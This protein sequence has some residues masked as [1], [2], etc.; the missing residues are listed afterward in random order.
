MSEIRHRALT[1]L[2]EKANSGFSGNK[3]LENKKISEIFGT[4]V[5][6]MNTMKEYLTEG[7]YYAILAVK[8]H[9]QN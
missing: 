6:D 1:G 4:N 8:K 2:H 3:K 5:F 7:A 9:N